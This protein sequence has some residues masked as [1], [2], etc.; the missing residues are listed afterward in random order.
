MFKRI[1]IGDA[2]SRP[3]SRFTFVSAKVNKT[4]DAQSGSITCD[5]RRKGKSGPTRY[6]QTRSAGKLERP[7]LRQDSRRQTLGMGGAW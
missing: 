5:G 2:G 1:D 4:I 6:V 3:G 7:S